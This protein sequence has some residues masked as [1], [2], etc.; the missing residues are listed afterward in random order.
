MGK[1]EKLWKYLKDTCLS[2]ERLSFDEI[3]AICGAHV[4]H[5]FMNSKRELE[6]YGLSV[7]KIDMNSRTVL[8]SRNA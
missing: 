5:D 2:T 1:Y 7:M 6:R 4:D 3:Y 8:F